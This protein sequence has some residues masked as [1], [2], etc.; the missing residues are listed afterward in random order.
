MQTE[1]QKAKSCT[2]V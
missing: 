1:S 2:I